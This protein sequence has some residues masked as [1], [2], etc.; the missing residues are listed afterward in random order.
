MIEMPRKFYVTTPIYYINAV[1]H[2]GHAYSTVAADIMARWHRLLGDDVFFLTGLDE[3][4][5]KT[6]EAAEEQGFDDIQEYADSMADNW[7]EVWDS[8]NISN[9]DFIR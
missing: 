3:N 5:A 6:V 7:L 2:I 4:S 9:D 8:L 1:P